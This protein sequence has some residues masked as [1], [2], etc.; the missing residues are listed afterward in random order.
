MS[1]MVEWKQS[2]ME[3][4]ENNGAGVSSTVF[5]VPSLFRRYSK[6]YDQEAGNPTVTITPDE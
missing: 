2:A 5:P 6:N 4:L 1:P 3:Y